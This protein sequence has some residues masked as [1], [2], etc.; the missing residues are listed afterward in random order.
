MSRTRQ[1]CGHIVEMGHPSPVSVHLPGRALVTALTRR[2]QQLVRAFVAEKVVAGQDVVDLKAFCA[3][4]A[5]ADVALQEALVM[6]DL[7]ALAVGE[8]ARL[9]RTPTRL[10]TGGGFH[11]SGDY[12]EKV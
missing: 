8:L 12:V 10:A 2:R 1:S 4:E 3:S 6:D 11:G 5:L 7:V 9:G